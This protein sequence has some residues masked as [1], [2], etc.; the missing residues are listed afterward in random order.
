MQAYKNVERKAVKNAKKHIEIKLKVNDV[1]I[2][3]DKDISKYLNDFFISVFTAEDLLNI[4]YLSPIQDDILNLENMQ[5]EHLKISA[6]LKKLKPFSAQ[7]PDKIS[8]RLL[9]EVAD[10]ICV[11]LAIIFEKSMVKFLV[12]EKRQI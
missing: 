12:I 9:I 6:K 5:F 2:D 11:P 10:T 3:E 8:S 7:G 4:P 1:L